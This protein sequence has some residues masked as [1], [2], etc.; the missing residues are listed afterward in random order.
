MRDFNFHHLII[1]LTPGSLSFNALSSS[2]LG[3]DT[4]GR[5]VAVN[6][7]EGRGIEMNIKKVGGD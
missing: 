1:S 2:V 4:E 6:S 7:D 3:V 5:V